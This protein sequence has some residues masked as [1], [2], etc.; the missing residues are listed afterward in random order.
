[1]SDNQAEAGV[2][3]ADV[4]RDAPAPPLAIDGR[5]PAAAGLA[6]ERANGLFAE[7]IEERY[8]DVRLAKAEADELRRF[9][10]GLRRGGSAGVRLICAGHN[11]DFRKACPLHKMKVGERATKVPD[12]DDPGR[13]VDA[14]VPVTKA[15]VGR[16]CPIEQ[17][18][19][20][21]AVAAYSAHPDVDVDNPVHRSYVGELA[22]LAALE[23][24]CDML[25]AFDHQNVVSEVPAAISPLGKL[26]TKFE[27][28]P[29]FDVLRDVQDRRSRIFK[30]LTLSREAEAKRRALEG[31][32]ED[33]L[34]RKQAAARAAIKSAE[35]VEVMP[36]PDAVKSEM[37]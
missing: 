32:G 3:L 5:D 10:S 6:L 13:L 23:W 2:S 27:K 29:V 22:Q 7:E 30:E 1:M 14:V 9:M 8:A 4:V 15:P 28:N 35:R 17:T 16:P 37:P 21:D 26:Y 20:L 12:P 11:C 34:S 31:G 24:R 33:S 18:V 19:V 25:L 36:V